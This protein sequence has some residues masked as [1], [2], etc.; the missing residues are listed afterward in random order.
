MVDV[1]YYPLLVYEETY[2]YTKISNLVFMNKK[3]CTDRLSVIRRFHVIE[4]SDKQ[5]ICTKKLHQVG[6]LFKYVVYCLYGLIL[7]IDH[8]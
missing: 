6:D 8:V 1:S 3:L 4:A 5:I 2:P 7:Y